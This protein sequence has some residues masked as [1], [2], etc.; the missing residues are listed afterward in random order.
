VAENIIEGSDLPSGGAYTSVGTYDHAE[1][2]SLVQNLS[3]ATSV[4]G[5]ALVQAFGR[6]MLSR[7]V[8][9]FPD[10]FVKTDNVISFLENVDGYIHGEVRKL[11]P[12]RGCRNSF[13]NDYPLT[14]SS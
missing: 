3:L 12:M 7:F 2:I 14:S 11:S 8:D 4:E 5:Q 9:M 13:P 10:F 1:L 6:H